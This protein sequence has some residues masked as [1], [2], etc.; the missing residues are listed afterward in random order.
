MLACAS[1]TPAG[2]SHTAGALAPGVT[3]AI[4]AL[5]SVSFAL[6]AWARAGLYCNHQA[7]LA[8]PCSPRP[9]WRGSTTRAATCVTSLQVHQSAWSRPRV[10]MRVMCELPTP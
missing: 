2:A 8:A 9:A 7:R 10:R 3:A 4:V 6:G 5:L 1:L